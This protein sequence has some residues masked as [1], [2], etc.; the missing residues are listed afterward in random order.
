MY[1]FADPSYQQSPINKDVEQ[2][3]RYEELQDVFEKKE[4][5]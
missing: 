3:S 5:G 1:K 4:R 2:V